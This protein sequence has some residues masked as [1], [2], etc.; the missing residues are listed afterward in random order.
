MEKLVEAARENGIPGLV[1]YTSPGNTS[2]IRLF[3]KLPYKITTALDD[4]PVN[5]T[6]KSSSS[7]LEYRPHQ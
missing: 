7:D 1:A 6:F 5:L 4:L 3:K 2:M